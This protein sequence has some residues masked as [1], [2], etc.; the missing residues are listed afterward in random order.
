MQGKMRQDLYQ[1]LY[2]VENTHWWHQHKRKVVHQFIAKFSRKIARKIVKKRDD[3][4]ITSS[5]ELAKT[6]EKTIPFKKS[7][8]RAIHPATRVFQALRIAVNR[9]L[10]RLEN[11]MKILPDM[12]LKGGRALIITFHSLEDRIVKH[13]IRKFENGCTCP[14]DLPVCLCGFVP[15][16]KSVYKKPIIPSPAELSANPMARSSKLRV[17]QRI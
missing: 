6:I 9:E 17:A 15:T 11:F 2:E 7:T 8:N 3:K 14:K 5:L 1:E 16:M 10:E 12:L 4:P 13:A